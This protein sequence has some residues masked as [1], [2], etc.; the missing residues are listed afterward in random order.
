MSI[1]FHRRNVN[2]SKLSCLLPKEINQQKFK[3]QLKLNSS[4]LGVILQS[5]I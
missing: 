3:T 4:T 5:F 2:M 1:F